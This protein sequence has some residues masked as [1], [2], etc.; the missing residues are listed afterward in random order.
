MLTGSQSDRAVCAG[1]AADHPLLRASGHGAVVNVGSIYGEMGPDWSLYDG[2]TM[3]NPAA[4]GASK[5]GLHQVTRWLA[6]TLA[7]D[8]RVNTPGS[9]GSSASNRSLLSQPI[10]SAPVGTDGA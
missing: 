2:T 1:A 3:A 7:P 8:I 4:Y 9:G 5:G 6:T 10:P